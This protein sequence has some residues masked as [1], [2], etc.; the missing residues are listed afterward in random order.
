MIGFFPAP[1]PR[2]RRKSSSSAPTTTTSASTRR[3]RSSTAPTTTP[4]APAP[5]SRSP[6]PSATAPS[7][8]GASPSSGSPARRRALL[9]SRLVRR[10]YLPA[11]IYKIVADINID[12]VSRNDGK[13]IGLTPS[14]KHPSHTSL[15]TWPEESAKAEGME[16]KYDADQYFF[17]TDSANFATQRHPGRLLLLGD[18]RGLPPADRRRREGR[19]RQG[20]P[21]RPGRLPA[22]LEGRPGPRAAEERKSRLS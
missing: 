3:G 2:R 15:A 4:R 7:R 14:E 18:P 11:R 5:C 17:R 1:T 20:R 16:V 6:R 10:P 22:R 9:G 12:M 21:R 19:L 8:P 13:S